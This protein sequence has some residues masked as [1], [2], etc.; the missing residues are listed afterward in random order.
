MSILFQPACFSSSKSDHSNIRE[1]NSKL[2]LNGVHFI[3]PKLPLF[4]HPP[5]IFF[6]DSD[7]LIKYP[8]IDGKSLHS[9]RQCSYPGI[10]RKI[11]TELQVYQFF[12]TLSS[13]V[14]SVQALSIISFP[15][16]KCCLMSVHLLIIHLLLFMLSGVLKISQK[17]QVSILSPSKLFRGCYLVQD[18]QINR[19][20]ISS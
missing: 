18:V 16:F 8:F 6:K 13:P 7:F 5:T 14:D 3:R 20:I 19:C 12:V 9:F 1:I 11:L 15:C 10:L 2:F 4:S 17:I